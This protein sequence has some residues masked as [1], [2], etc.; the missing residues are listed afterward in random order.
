MV[1]MSATTSITGSTLVPSLRYR[2]AP[3]AIDWLCKAFGF[4]R[5]AVYPNPDGTIAH[6]ELALGQGMVMLGSAKNTGLAAQYSVQPSEIG[7]RQTGGI[8]LVVDDC[9]RVYADVQAVGATVVQDLH[10]PDYGGKAFIC[11]DP[12]GYLWSVG[13]YDPWAHHPATS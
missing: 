5:H 6:A 2:D 11:L 8:Y 7:G 12:E 9:D 4:R 1:R 13:S 10:E 3:A